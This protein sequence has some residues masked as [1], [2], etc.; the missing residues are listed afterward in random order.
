[1]NYHHTSIT[2]QP[3][4][5]DLND[6]LGLGWLLGKISCAQAHQVTKVKGQRLSFFSSLQH[7]FQR[8]PGQFFSHLLHLETPNGKSPAPMQAWA[9]RPDNTH[10]QPQDA[11]QSA[12]A[13]TFPV[14]TLATTSRRAHLSDNWKQNVDQNLLSID[15]PLTSPKNFPQS[16]PAYHKI[17]AMTG[18]KLNQMQRASAFAPGVLKPVIFQINLLSLFRTKL[19]QTSSTFSDSIIPSLFTTSRRQA[20]V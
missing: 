4:S 7:A 16:R 10:F 19:L 9:S 6:L 13:C 8:P 1:M 3:S 20:R 18:H 5:M 12:V 2:L 15:P 11:A 14:Q 17:A